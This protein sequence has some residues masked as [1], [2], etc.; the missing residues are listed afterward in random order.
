ML[1]LPPTTARD[2]DG[3]GNTGKKIFTDIGFTVTG[4]KSFTGKNR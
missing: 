4:K 1:Q 3:N 2:E